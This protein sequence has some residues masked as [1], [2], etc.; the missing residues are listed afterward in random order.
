MKDAHK[1]ARTS[2]NCNISFPFITYFFPFP[3]ACLHTFVLIANRR[4][5][6]STSS[7]LS[8]FPFYS[9]PALIVMF[10][11]YAYFSIMSLLRRFTLFLQVFFL[12]SYFSFALVFSTLAS[13]SKRLLYK[14][15]PAH[16][17]LSLM[18]TVP[19]SLCKGIRSIQWGSEVTNLPIHNQR[20]EK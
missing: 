10:L 13:L 12:F 15:S 9:C 20:Y 17:Y 18:F 11:N 8:L 3:P 7:D 19:R 1:A 14:S 5:F 2:T 4:Q 16:P 6:S